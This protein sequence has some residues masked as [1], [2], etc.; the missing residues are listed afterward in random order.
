MARQLMEEAGYAD[1]FDVT[2]RVSAQYILDLANAQVLQ[3]QLQAINVN[4]TLEQL[5]WGNLLDAWVNKDFEMLNI[6][7]LGLPDP[8]GYTR[9]RY[10][11]ESTS[12][13]NQISD[14]ELD[15]MMDDARATVDPA[16]RQAKYAEIQ[17][18]L[19][20]LTPNLFYYVID[21]WQVW[22]PRYQGVTPLPNASAPYLKEVWIDE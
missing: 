4:I 1:G 22:D 17:H 18:R 12:N 15:T 2:L 21:S 3:Q 13:R 6:L 8:D 7:L 20:A 10:H 9:G 11:T 5:E 16:E 14:P 19:D